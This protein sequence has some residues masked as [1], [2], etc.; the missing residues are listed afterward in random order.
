MAKVRADRSEAARLGTLLANEQG[1]DTRP[2][3][4]EVPMIDSTRP[5]LPAALIA[6][7]RGALLLGALTTAGPAWAAPPPALADESLAADASADDAAVD[8]EPA[9][10]PRRAPGQPS[11]YLVYGRQIGPMPPVSPSPATP[12]THHAEPDMVERGPG[13]KVTGIVLT[14]LGTV[15]AGVGAAIAG[16]GSQRA[17][18]CRDSRRECDFVGGPEELMGGIVAGAGGLQV[19]V[20]IPLLA[21][22]A[23]QRP[24]EPGETASRAGAEST[25]DPVPRVALGLGSAQLTWDF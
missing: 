8:P 21:V 17:Q 23:S 15:T 20:G 12:Y 11:E 14:V 3:P 16:A 24:V 4:S 6:L 19:L 9:A 5:R 1:N 13:M 18:S 2:Q 22:G 25:I 7:V 10:A